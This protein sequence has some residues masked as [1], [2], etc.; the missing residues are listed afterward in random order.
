MQLTVRY[1]EIR[2]LGDSVLALGEI[3]G[4]GRTSRVDT[5]SEIAQLVTYREA[6]ALRLRDFPSHAEGLRAAG[7]PE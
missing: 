4:T 5:G 6:K 7:V 3:A 1:E 2:D